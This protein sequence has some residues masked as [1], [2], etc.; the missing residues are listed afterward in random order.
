MPALLPLLASV[1]NLSD[2]IGEAI[3]PN[4]PDSKRAN[5]ALRAASNLVR[6]ETGKSWID[7]NDQ[8]KAD[9]TL[10]EDLWI[11]VMD[12]A[13]RKYLN[14]EG[15][16]QEREDQWYGSRKVQEAGVYLTATELATC[17]SYLRPA[18][19]GLGTI[20]TT[21]DDYPKCN[22]FLGLDDYYPTRP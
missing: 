14:P 7:P 18:N 11:V 1:T 22:E 8:T 2:H 4:T 20:Q 10:P 17:E 21:R 19:R 15:F 3:P 13:G 6:R 16:E 9:P 5:G 12:A